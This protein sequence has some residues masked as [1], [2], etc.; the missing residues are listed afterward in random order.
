ML[1]HI[2]R[3]LQ[4]N[5]KKEIKW[6]IFSKEEQTIVRYWRFFQETKEKPENVSPMFSS[7]SQ[8]HPGDPQPNTPNYSFSENWQ[9]SF[10]RNSATPSGKTVETLWNEWELWPWKPLTTTNLSHLPFINVALPPK[11]PWWNLSPTKQRWVRGGGRETIYAILSVFPY[12]E[13]IRNTC[14]NCICLN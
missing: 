13:I 4:E 6:S 14:T 7:C 10:K 1:W 2:Q 11:F 8:F 12:K 3:I 5:E 9:G